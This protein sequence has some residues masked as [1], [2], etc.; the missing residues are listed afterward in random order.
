[1]EYQPKHRKSE[2]FYD[3]PII[4]IKCCKEF[5]T[6][7]IP[8]CSDYAAYYLGVHELN[9]NNYRVCREHA[10]GILNEYL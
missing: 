4:K 5:E 9:A 10:K 8:D 1:M 7:Q 3:E 6:C 2:E